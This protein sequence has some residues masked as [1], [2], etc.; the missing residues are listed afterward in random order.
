M[1]RPTLLVVLCALALAACELPQNQGSGGD[2]SNGDADGATVIRTY[3]YLL[4]VDEEN[5][6]ASPVPGPDIDAIVFFQDGDFLFAGCSQANLFGQDDL[7]YPENLHENIDA[8]TLSVREDSIASGFLSLAGGTLFCEL[9][10]QVQTGD[11]LIVWEVEGD[12]AERWQASFAAKADGE[13]IQA[14]VKEGSAEFLV[15]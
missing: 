15:P 7:K 11:S 10:L 14:P 12:G 13:R 9:P 3:R 1:T 5:A 6:S 8:A 4:L 2:A